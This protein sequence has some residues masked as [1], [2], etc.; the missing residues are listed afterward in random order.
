MHRLAAQR[1]L[2][3]K[4]AESQMVKRQ[5]EVVEKLR[6]DLQDL[7]SRNEDRVLTSFRALVYQVPNISAQ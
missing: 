5:A 2:L 6:Q 7:K 4:L 1:V 3:Q